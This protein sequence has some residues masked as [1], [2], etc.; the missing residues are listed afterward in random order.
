L[1]LHDDGSRKLRWQITQ[2]DR[3][4]RDSRRRATLWV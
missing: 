3:N 4:A 1:S 2:H